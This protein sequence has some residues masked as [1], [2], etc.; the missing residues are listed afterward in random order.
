M[1][2]SRGQLDGTATKGNSDRVLCFIRF[3]VLHCTSVVYSRTYNTMN[4]KTAAIFLLCLVSSLPLAV[5]MPFL[6]RRWLSA[7]SPIQQVRWCL[8]CT[9]TTSFVVL[10]IAL[11][12]HSSKTME[13]AL[14]KDTTWGSMA[15]EGTLDGLHDSSGA[16]NILVY[17]SHTRE[18]KIAGGIGGGGRKLT[19][20]P[21][22]K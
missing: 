10:F 20:P 6:V 14:V 18:M 3:E 19:G 2:N 5:L 7:W 11:G 17:G 22:G 15:N 8:R 4:K 9:Y 12:K 1:H 13:S 16:Q 21:T